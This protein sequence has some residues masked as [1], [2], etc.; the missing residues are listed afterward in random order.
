M[1]K[2]IDYTKEPVEGRVR[3]CSICGKPGLYG[4]NPECYIHK[5][6]EPEANAGAGSAW[7]AENCCYVNLRR[8]LKRPPEG[9]GFSDI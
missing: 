3:I 7:V 4:R 1:P 8:D 6:W 5:M 9:K 2:L